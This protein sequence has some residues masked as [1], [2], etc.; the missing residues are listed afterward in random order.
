[1]TR[2]SLLAEPRTGVG[3]G[4]VPVAASGLGRWDARGGGARRAVET[5]EKNR[6]PRKHQQHLKTC[7]CQQNVTKRRRAGMRHLCWGRRLGEVA[8]GHREPGRTRSLRN[9]QTQDSQTSFQ[10]WGSN[11]PRWQVRHTPLC[12]F[13][14]LHTHSPSPSRQ[15]GSREDSPTCPRWPGSSLSHTAGGGA[16]DTQTRSSG[17]VPSRP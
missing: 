7:H 8:P 13:G 17:S 2:P 6:R 15:D 3:P 4:E 12:L 14:L 10:P 11:R 16:G 9:L 1:M 5:E